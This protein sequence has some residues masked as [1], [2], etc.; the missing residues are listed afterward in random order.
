MRNKTVQK[1]G[2]R[3]RIS[4]QLYLVVQSVG[5]RVG[6]T[7]GPS[8]ELR[9]QGP[10]SGAELAAPGPAQPP[11]SVAGHSL[12]AA[13]SPTPCPVLPRNRVV[14]VRSVIPDTS[15]LPHA[16]RGAPWVWATHTPPGVPLGRPQ[17]LPFSV[18]SPTAPHTSRGRCSWVSP[19]FSELRSHDRMSSWPC[20]PSPPSSG[21]AAS[22]PQT[23]R[24]DPAPIPSVFP[25]ARGMSSKPK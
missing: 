10:C 21:L 4:Q 14:A 15:S 23:P 8:A 12:A 18:S 1:S 22:W 2:G 5:R 17:L 6:G 7:S 9:P 20:V 25:G 13:L 19:T 16:H 24:R 3:S 11:I